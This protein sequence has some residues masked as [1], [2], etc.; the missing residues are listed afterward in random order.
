MVS[1][2]VL[3]LNRW[4]PAAVTVAYKGTPEARN[5]IFRTQLAERSDEGID[6]E[7]LA[8]NVL[9]TT[10]ELVMKDRAKLKKFR[11]E[12]MERHCA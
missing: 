9:L 5:D 6:G 4:L 11:R 10:Y 2:Q 12:R 8:F 1:S 3:E 7:G